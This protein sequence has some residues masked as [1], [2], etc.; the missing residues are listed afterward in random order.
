MYTADKN[1]YDSLVKLSVTY[2]NEGIDHKI[3]TKLVAKNNLIATPYY[4][5]YMKTVRQHFWTSDANEYNVLRVQLA[6]FNDGGIDGYIFLNAGVTSSV[7]LYRLVLNK[8][9]IH[10]LTIDNNEFDFL[11]KSESW[12]LE[13]RPENPSGFTGYVMPK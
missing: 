12:T 8:T 9:P 11:V 1:E 2:L 4:P 13:R 5:L 10:L 3:F 7:P 6:L